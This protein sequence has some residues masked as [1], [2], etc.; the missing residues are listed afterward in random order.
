MAPLE[1]TAS[2]DVDRPIDAVWAVVQDV[3]AWPQWQRSLGALR[4]L[5][6]DRDGRLSV[7][8][9]TLDA[10]VAQLTMRLSCAYEPPARL[11]FRRQS[12]DLASLEG[13]WLL[14]DAG[15][16]RTRATYE[17]AVDPGGILRFLLNEARTRRLREILVD[18]RPGELK[19][20]A[21]G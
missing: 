3:A 12:G 16:G 1:G 13:A 9:M 14:A 7:C 21:E 11:S 18:V 17:L 15:D 10:G 20:R 4:A 5:E 19:A 2:A 6:H 8:E